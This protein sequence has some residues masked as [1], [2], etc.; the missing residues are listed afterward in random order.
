[1][2]RLTKTFVA[3]CWYR[4]LSPG[5]FEEISASESNEGPPIDTQIRQWVDDTGSIIIHPGQLG[6]HTSWHGT[7]EDP[8]Q[9]KCLT[10]GLTVLYQE[11]SNGQ[12]EPIQHADPRGF[13]PGASALHP[14]AEN[15]RP[16][17]HDERPADGA[18]ATPPGG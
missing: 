6:M 4:R 18:G 2:R 15:P 10:F 1:M 8:F 13:D 16:W 11:A 5:V 17:G 14:G 9:L 3:N 12:R 7:Q